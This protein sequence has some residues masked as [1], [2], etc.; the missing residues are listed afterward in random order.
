MA[1]DRMIPATARRR[2]RSRCGHGQVLPGR[3]LPPSIARVASN[4]IAT[5]RMFRLGGG[6]LVALILGLVLGVAVDPVAGLIAAAA[7]AAAWFAAAALTG[8]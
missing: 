7:A 1:G 5:D 4:A 2:S 8:R 6:L 3:A